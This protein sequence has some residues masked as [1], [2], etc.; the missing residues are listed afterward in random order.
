MQRVT[1]FFT[2]CFLVLYVGAQDGAD[3]YKRNCAACHSIG[4]GRLVG[5]D[6]AGITKRTDKAWL[7]K[8]IKNSADVIKSGDPA[9]VAIGKEYNN[10][11]MPPFVGTDSELS[12]IIMY[13]DSKGGSASSAVAD[14]FLNSATF[15]NIVR[16]KAL[17]AGN[18][19]FKNA[20]TPCITCHAVHNDGGV[21]G[22]L[23][24]GLNLSYFMLKGQGLKAML[25]SPPFP[26]M[27]NAYGNHPL[28]E[29]EVYDLAA[30]L[31][32]VSQDMV[33][34]KTDRATVPFLVLGIGG[35]CI[36]V[37]ILLGLWRLRKRSS[38]NHDIFARQLATEK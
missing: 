21:G 15:D 11:L 8:F 14:T 18:S 25:Q 24:K 30:Y 19:P 3:L 7:T 9:A 6:L 13:I 35:W 34:G 1:I 12:A 22:T 36:S 26:A 29:Q 20:G 38:V 27:A 4:G 17:F 28:N 33:D 32:S 2:F 5:P 23:A 16:G 10:L 31:K 37:L